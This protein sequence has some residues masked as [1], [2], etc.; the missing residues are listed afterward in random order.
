M[1]CA[2]SA[3]VAASRIRRT[4]STCSSVRSWWNSAMNVSGSSSMLG[5]R[6][7]T[8]VPSPWRASRIRAS[9]S[10]R[11]ASRS[12]LRERP[13]R[14]A[15]SASFGSRS[16]AASSPRMIIALMSSMARSVTLIGVLR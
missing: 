6:L 13:R 12:E 14:V 10:A 16:P 3:A 1:Y 11:T 15:R 4:S 7:V 8:Y 2:A 9:V 5:S